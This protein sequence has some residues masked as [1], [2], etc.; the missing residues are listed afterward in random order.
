MGALI[1]LALT[2]A[3]EI[4]RWLFGTAGE[5]TAQAVAQVVATVT[6]TPD[7]VAAQAVLARDPELA[8]KLRVQLA[9]IAATQEAADR[10][11]GL[12]TLKA[13]LADVQGARAQ[14]VALAQAKSAVQWAPA[15]VSFVV[16]LTFGVVM[17]AALTRQLPAGSET[18]LNMLLGTL[19]AMATSVVGYWVGSSAGSSR[20]TDLLYQSTPAPAGGAPG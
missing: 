20:K 14:T 19:A 5:H 8:G 2:L 10:Q 17:W 6:G 7:A 12:D 1:P 3:P 15:I 13:Q 11:T 18:I 9:Q 4:G 16:L